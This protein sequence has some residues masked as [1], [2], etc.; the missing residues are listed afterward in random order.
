[1]WVALTLSPTLAK[2]EAGIPLMCLQVTFYFGLAMLI[3][4]IKNFL[5]YSLYME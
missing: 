1:M 2:K 4:L 3:L 5:P